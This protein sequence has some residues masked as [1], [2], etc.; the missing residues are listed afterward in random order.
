MDDNLIIQLNNALLIRPEST[1]IKPIHIDVESL[2]FIEKLKELIDCKDDDIATLSL[3]CPLQDLIMICKANFLDNDS[4]YNFNLITEP[5]F[6]PVV[7]LGIGFTDESKK[8]LV[9]KPLDK[10]RYKKAYEA[11][12][13]IKEIEE[14]SGA[15]KKIRE[16]GKKA[17]LEEYMKTLSSKFDSKENEEDNTESKETSEE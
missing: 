8:E 7:I 1:T 4:E 15:L 3:P 12:S 9:I 10:E 2:N 13:S 6:G 5:I 17:F 14:S 11:F 16:M